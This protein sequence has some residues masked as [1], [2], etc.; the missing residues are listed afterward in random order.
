MANLIDANQMTGRTV[1]ITGAT[2]GIGK[3]TAMGLAALGANLLI[4]GRDRTRTEATAREIKLA[5]PGVSVDLMLA[6]LASL[7]AVRQL[8]EQVNQNFSQLH[9]LINNA[10][11]LNITR[12]V[13]VDGF[14]ETFQVD[15]LASFLLTNL[16]LPL[17]Q[18]SGKARI[19]TVSSGIHQTATMRW[20]DLQGEKQYGEY[21]AYA[22][23]NLAR[24]LFSYELARRL[25]DSDMTANCLHPGGVATNMGS[26]N[27]SLMSSL[28]RLAAPFLKKP[29][30]GA[31]TS[32]YL[33]SSPEVEGV[34]GKYFV[35]C[36]ER[37]SSKLS[38]SETDAQRLWKI[39]EELVGLGV[40]AR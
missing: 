38:Y 18:K 16:L 17:L 33:A 30:E 34:S 5:F 35:N 31:R 13:T 2:S 15:Y 40:G 22:Q 8:A 12:K 20:D 29:E 1:L 27:K 36:K 10:G 37:K 4:V 11:T 32:I 28:F 24:I 21:K 19:V 39:S 26:S 7:K 9:V 6:D 23:A 3:A 25:K 14:E